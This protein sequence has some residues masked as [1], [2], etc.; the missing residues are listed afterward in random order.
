MKRLSLLPLLALAASASFAQGKFGND[1]A[2][3]P[4][5]LKAHLEFIASDE[6]QG[7]D[8][9]SNGLD[10][11]AKYLAAQLSLWGAMPG[12]DGR[13]YFQKI[14][15]SRGRVVFD[16]STLEFDGKQYPYGTGFKAAQSGGSAKAGLVYVGHGYM[17]KAKGIDPY[18]GMDVKGKI[19]VVVSGMP[20]G[21]SFR[22]MQGEPGKDYMWPAMAA[23]MYGAAG[24]V[25]IPDAEY[26]K[27][28]QPR[29]ETRMGGFSPETPGEKSVPT[30]TASAELAQALLAGE[31]VTAE[32]AMNNSEAPDTGF[33]L[34]SSK[35]LKM[36][37]AQESED[38]WTQNVVAIVPGTDPKLK[39]EYVA[40]GAHYDHVGMRTSGTGDRIFNGADDDGSGTV[41]ILEICHAY[42]TGPKPK[43]SLLFVWHCGEEKGLWGSDYF[44]EHPTVDIKSIVTQL[45]IDMIG[46]S[47]K[48]GDTNPA[49][50]V[51]TGPKE[52]YVVGST[53]MS[54]DL[55]TVS[56]T[57]N[58]SFLNLSF[59]YKYD[60]PKD[61]E[62]IFYRSD[63]YNYARKG[64]PIIFYFDGVHEDY[65]R[66]GDEVQR[67]DFQKMSEVAR[68]VY[69]TGWTVANASKRPVVD[70]PLKD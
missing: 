67:I 35:S 49:N 60:D 52:I 63:H 66:P 46:R 44:T 64:I 62:R 12:G 48:E 43:R 21:L 9:P 42:L 2:I 6:L 32:Q 33:A 39:S 65:H 70:K 68:T 18:K 14:K 51:L 53:K 50:K 23:Q 37:V 22:D 5:R 16:K 28:W 3:T 8:T 19:L 7:R 58:K 56:E 31:K 27:D 34:S 15:L 10:T 54:T 61:T 40:F 26:L 30:V 36:E 55:Q 17:S 45:N 29:T 11:A 20:K 4:A 1:A 69:A 38:Q 57:V 24:V 13:T 47:K 25:T 59:N 41:S